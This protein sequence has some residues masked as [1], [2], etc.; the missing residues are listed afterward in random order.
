MDSS[1]AL[2]EKA[3]LLPPQIQHQVLD[4]VDFLLS[5]YAGHR[6]Q[7]PKAGCM[8]GTFVWMSDDFNAPL[9]DFKDYQ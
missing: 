9:D 5:K 4:Y 6:P 1:V 3:R 7:K 8:K 2:P